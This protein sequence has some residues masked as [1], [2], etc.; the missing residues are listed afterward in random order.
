MGR[1]AYRSNVRLR[2]R[3]GLIH[4]LIVLAAFLTLGLFL[5]E[6]YIKWRHATPIAVA[7]ND[8]EIYTGSILFMP[9]EGKICHQLLFDNRT[10]EFSDNGDVDCERAAYQG[11]EPKHWSAARLRAVSSGFFH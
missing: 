9:P 4:T 3:D 7:P 1:T 5:N 11:A 8:D 2:I 6:Q 10:G